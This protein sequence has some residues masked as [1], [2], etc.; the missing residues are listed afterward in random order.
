MAEGHA[1][2]GAD[3]VG[4]DRSTQDGFLGA[5]DVSIDLPL[6]TPASRSLAYFIDLLVLALIATLLFAGGMFFAAPMIELGVDP[7]TMVAGAF[8]AWFSLEWGW[9]VMWEALSG[10][11]TPGKRSMGLRVVRTNG[12]PVGLISAIVRNLLRPI[13]TL[14]GGLI[15]L[16]VGLLTKRHQR[17]GDLAAGTVV[18]HAPDLREARA[19][20]ARWPDGISPDDVALVE[21][22]FDREP[23]LADAARDAIAARMLGWVERTWP[24]FVTTS[25]APSPEHPA[26]VLRVAFGAE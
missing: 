21:A 9:F 2:E 13:D 24:G 6:A 1:G 23:I 7:G 19:T 3:S 5:L 18:V 17:L 4:P 16:L 15:G 14:G 10:G 8:I 11:L 22:W 20:P 12:Q 26:E 25:P